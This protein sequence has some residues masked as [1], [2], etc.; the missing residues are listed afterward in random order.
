MSAGRLTLGYRAEA[1]NTD[2]Y[3]GGKHSFQTCDDRFRQRATRRTV[4]QQ[5][6]T[7]PPGFELLYPDEPFEVYVGP[8]YFRRDD[9]GLVGGFRA[10]L[11]HTNSG[12]AVH[13]GALSAFAD[14]ALTGFALQQMSPEEG[15][16][17][18]ITLNCEFLAPANLGDWIECRGTVVKRTRSLVFARGEITVDRQPV[19]TCSSVLRIVKRSQS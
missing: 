1:V 15:W 13:G 12:G 8:H 4:H 3:E 7:P 6:D 19:L 17:A 11:Q 5:D 16:V 10:K 14:S 9:D 2:R 18:T